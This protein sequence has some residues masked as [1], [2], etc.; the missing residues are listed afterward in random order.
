MSN[1]KSAILII[2]A[3]HMQIE[4]IRWAKAFDLHVIVTDSRNTATAIDYADDYYQIS[5]SDV[6]KLT[7]LAIKLNSQFNLIGAYSGSDFGLASVA[8]IHKRLNLPGCS[9]DAVA[10]ALDKPRAKK[11]WIDLGLPTP[12]MELW[13]EL[14]S[15]KQINEISYPIIVKPLDSCGSQGVTS[16]K[17]SSQLPAA[18]SL[19]SSFGTPVLME[20]YFEGIGI[21]TIGI[22]RNGEFIPCG[23]GDRYFSSPHHFPTHGVVPTSLADDDVK[24]AYELTEQ[25]CRALGLNNTPVKADLLYRNGQFTIIEVSPRFH[26]DVFTTKLIPFSTGNSPIQNWFSL[27]AN[28]DTEKQS[29]KPTKTVIW[30]ALFPLSDKIDFNEVELYLEKNTALLEFFYESRRYKKHHNH[31]DNTSLVGFFWAAVN[32]QQDIEP[33]L[34]SFSAQFNGKLL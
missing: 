32:N 20:E 15:Y 6:T 22:M 4:H 16:V 12:R 29:D 26:G 3:G 24:Q 30:K 33:F 28:K 5:G 25:A 7:E 27:L 2:G 14:P 18:F 1:S 31:Q 10:L 13:K 19:A 8:A 21:D 17:D 34:D 23:I 9:P 11:I